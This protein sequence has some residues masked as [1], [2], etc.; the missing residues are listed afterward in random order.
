GP[1]MLPPL[2]VTVKVCARLAVPTVCAGVN[3]WGE[4]VIVIVPTPRPSPTSV[5][6]SLPPVVAVA[7]IVAVRAPVACG[8]KWRTIVH[9]AFGASAAVQSDDTSGKSASL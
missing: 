9:V 4:G 7:V 2:L 1:D 6:V 3:T 5:A 8:V